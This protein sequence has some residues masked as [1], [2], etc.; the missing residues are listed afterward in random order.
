MAIKDAYQGERV[1]KKRRLTGETD[2][3]ELEAGMIP[4]LAR[5]FSFTSRIAGTVLSNLPSSAYTEDGDESLKSLWEEVGK[6]GWTVVWNCLREKVSGRQPAKGSHGKKRKHEVETHTLSTHC[7]HI[8]ASAILRFLYDIRAR[9]SSPL[10]ECDQLGK[11]DAE[12]LLDVLQDEASD[13]DL[14]LETV[15]GFNSCDS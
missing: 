5:A 8:A 6:L 15:R 7:R 3:N 4:V 11:P 2:T 1:G 9:V 12:T 13:P 10:G 14:I